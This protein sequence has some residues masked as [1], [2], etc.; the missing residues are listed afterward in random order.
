MDPVSKSNTGSIRSGFENNTGSIRAPIPDPMDPVSG[1][2]PDL[3]DPVSKSNTGSIRSGF[4]NNTGSI[5]APIPDPMDPSAL[6]IRDNYLEE[7]EREEKGSNTVAECEEL[8]PSLLNSNSGL[9]EEEK[10]NTNQQDPKPVLE[11]PVI[12]EKALKGRL[13]EDIARMN[14]RVEAGWLEGNEEG[15]AVTHGAIRKA[16]ALKA[17]PHADVS[18]IIPANAALEA[19]ILTTKALNTAAS[20]VGRT[21]VLKRPQAANAGSKVFQVSDWLRS[22]TEEEKRAGKGKDDKLPFWDFERIWMTPGEVEE[23]LKEWRE[24]ELGDEEYRKG[25]KRLEEK[26]KKGA[27]ARHSDATWMSTFLLE[28]ACRAK[29]SKLA[30]KREMSW[31]R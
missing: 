12:P 20:S 23:T 21:T 30:L 27:A 2:I 24:A 17:N 9:E 14:A 7:E 18:Q 13:G 29:K 6:Y 22:L 11:M 1:A 3:M 5:G 19:Q 26:H 31:A 28:D 25:L 16:Q 8:T 10:L 4:E 15:W